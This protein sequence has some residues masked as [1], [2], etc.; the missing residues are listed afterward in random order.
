MAPSAEAEGLAGGCIDAVLLDAA[1]TLIKP[2]KPVGETYA[3]V[4][5]R[6]GAALEPD[7]LMQGFVE[8]FGDMP[9]LAFRWTTMEELQRL[10]RNWWRTLVLRVVAS[11]GSCI[12]DFDAFFGDLYGHY[13][14]GD[15]WECFAEVPGVL[16]RLRAR[17]CKLAVVSNFDSRLPVILRALGIHG[18]LD[19]VVYSSAAGCVKPD[20]AIFERALAELGVA[21]ERALHVGDSVEADVGGAISAGLSGFLIR[22]ESSPGGVSDK[23]LGS[24]EEL[25]VRSRP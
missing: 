15:A 2:R 16:K 7:R 6:Y 3:E 17:G 14:Q 25:L 10:E 19:A 5:E 18:Y 4:A 21:P 24:L 8:A 11:V 23:L 12:G 20:P 22:R 9:D 13:A 1:G